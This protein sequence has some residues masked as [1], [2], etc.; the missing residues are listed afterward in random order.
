MQEK[1]P[2]LVAVSSISVSTSHWQPLRSAL[3]PLQRSLVKSRG[4]DVSCMRDYA[5]LSL[6]CFSQNP[7]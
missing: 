7:I 4:L 3:N 2:D 1:D 5:F 6:M